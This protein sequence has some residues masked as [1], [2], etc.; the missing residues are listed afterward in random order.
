MGPRRAEQAIAGQAGDIPEDTVCPEAAEVGIELAGWTA[1]AT[2]G[3][4]M[5][6]LFMSKVIRA[7]CELV[8]LGFVFAVVMVVMVLIAA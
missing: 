6:R 5:T 4:V 3:Y 7:V 2:G 8:A 1:A